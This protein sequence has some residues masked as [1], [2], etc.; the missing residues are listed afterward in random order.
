MRGSSARQKKTSGHQSCR[1][2]GSSTGASRQKMA[3][4]ISDV[5]STERP[6]VIEITLA[7]TGGKVRLRRDQCEF[8][9]GKVY[10]PL[11]LGRRVTKTEKQVG[12]DT[13]A[14]IDDV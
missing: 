10:V 13:D 5:I 7:D 3:L 12:R 4:A 6:E 9:P 2:Y 8:F 1:P 14:E 11:W